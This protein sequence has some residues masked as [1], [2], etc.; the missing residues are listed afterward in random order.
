MFPR[1]VIDLAKVKNNSKNVVEKCHSLGVEVAG[2]TKV[3]CGMPE[4]AEAMIETNIDMIAD[5]RMQNIK[6]LK[7]N[8][9][10]KDFLLLR[11]PMISELDELI[12]NVDITLISELKTIKILGEKALAKN[13]KQKIIFMIDLG[14]LREGV[15]YKN[16]VENI[17]K[18]I[19]IQGIELIG[20]GTNLGCFGGV[21]PTL[22]KMNMLVDIKTEVK[23]K[24]NFEL[25]YISAGSTAALPLVENKDLPKEINH[26]R[27]GESILCGT[28]VTN[29]RKVPGAYQ[30]AVYLE[31]EIV[32][33]KEKP[34]MPEGEIGLDAFGRKPH[35]ED[36]GWRKKCILAVGEQDI[37]PEG[38]IPINKDIEVLH[39]SSDHTIIDITE[40]KSDYNI[41]DIIRFKLSYSALLKATTS[42]YVEKIIINQ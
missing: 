34:S 11:I 35:F 29:N 3:M 9:I 24:L 14:D 38:L 5:A 12:E 21:L 42:Q 23:E 22:E 8:G 1:L 2:V 17:E 28:D 15:W 33:I 31:A 36:K 27:L 25:K 16:A 6:K 26:Y 10:K 41:G 19:E 40:C 39:A 20:I 13:K 7:G 30:D 37:D 32:E 4:I 18:I